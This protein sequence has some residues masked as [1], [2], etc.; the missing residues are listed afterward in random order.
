MVLV[1]AADPCASRLS[2]SSRRI[3][4]SCTCFQYRLMLCSWRNHYK[5]Y[6]SG[7][8]RHRESAPFGR[9]SLGASEAGVRRQERCRLIALQ[10][11][12]A[13]PEEETRRG[14]RKP[15][16]I[17]ARKKVTTY[18]IRVFPPGLG[19]P[20]VLCMTA[21]KTATAA[22]PFGQRR[23]DDFRQRRVRSTNTVHDV[24]LRVATS[25]EP[26]MTLLGPPKRSGSATGCCTNYCWSATRCKLPLYRG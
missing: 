24:T 10:P 13:K 22:R 16:V 7:D 21:T 5:S 12:G 15:L 9:P 20:P 4:A 23:P 11:A 14:R 19:T 3:A 2:R 17:R 26:N 6:G 8:W 25:S 1:S 18:P